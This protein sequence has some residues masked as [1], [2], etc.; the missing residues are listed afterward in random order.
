MGKISEALSRFTEESRNRPKEQEPPPFPPEALQPSD[1]TAL[2]AY[3]PVSKHILRL[4]P[5]DDAKNA[6]SL[7]KLKESGTIERL[8]Q[9]GLLYPGGKLTARGIAEA[10]RVKG[11][12]R[13]RIRQRQEPPPAAGPRG[14]ADGAERPEAVKPSPAPPP[15]AGPEVSLAEFKRGAPAKPAFDPG[16]MDRT[17]V[18]LLAPRSEEAEQ[19]KILRTN[20]LYPVSGLPPR[21]I[22]VTSAAPGEGKSF[23]AANLAVSIAMNINRYVLLIDADL[24]KPDLHRRFGYG[25]T[26]GLGD[27]LEQG[28]P[29][30]RFL[31]KTS[32]EKLT[33]LPAGRPPDNPSELISS[34]RMAGL[35][36][37][38][39]NRYKDRLIVVDAPPIAVAS[40]SGV[41]ARQVEGILVVIRHGKTRREEMQNLL[42]RVQPEKL[43][44]CFING[45]ER[46]AARYYGYYSYGRKR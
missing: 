33:L 22:L 4:D 31:L 10:E 18:T 15:G 43:L 2:A 1:I 8:I 32:V 20:I 29:L 27:Y 25:E 34:E 16:A 38:V 39:A 37:E 3:D 12:H 21:T 28:T 11:L 9:N 19:F 42:S 30:P 23:V 24:R 36:E 13:E 17:L 40:E 7:E 41:L 35:L 46:K 14:A 26:P 45:I 6:A 5:Q 44:G